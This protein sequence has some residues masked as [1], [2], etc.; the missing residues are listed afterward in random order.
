[1]AKNGDFQLAIDS[2]ALIVKAR[3]KGDPNCDRLL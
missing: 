3:H 2:L 1:M